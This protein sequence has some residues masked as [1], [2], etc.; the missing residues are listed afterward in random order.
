MTAFIAR[1]RVTPGKEEAFVKL[2]QELYRLT[3]NHEPDT[4]V[5]ELLKS[6]DEPNTYVVIATF[7]DEP[8]FQEH[9]D[10]SFHDELVPPILDCLSS[11]MELEM[12]DCIS[13]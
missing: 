11:D 6:R 1:L 10:S 8:A 13:T 7:K 3:H 9:M 5:Y 2:Q 4:P 12:L